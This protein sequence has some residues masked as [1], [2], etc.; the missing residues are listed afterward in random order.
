MVIAPLIKP[1]T[2]TLLPLPTVTFSSPTSVIVLLCILV[3]VL[4][5]SCLT[6]SSIIAQCSKNAD[7]GPNRTSDDDPEHHEQII[8]VIIFN[9]IRREPPTA[10]AESNVLV[11]GGGITRREADSGASRRSH[12]ECG[13]H[14][15]PLRW[16]CRRRM[17]SR[18][19]RGC[20]T[21]TW[22]GTGGTSWLIGGA[23]GRILRW[24][25]CRWCRGTGRW[26]ICRRGGHRR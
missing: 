9:F 20:H 15:G 13:L 10:R 21:D 7:G 2:M 12:G 5:L 11:A 16:R 14:A 3:V 23:K 22:T 19:V 4:S 26:L 24:D 18:C 25:V 1:G 17:L 8:L 6:A